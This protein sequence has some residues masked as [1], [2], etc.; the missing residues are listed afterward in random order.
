MSEDYCYDREPGTCPALGEAQAELDAL[1]QTM[2][3][4][5]DLAADAAKQ[6]E[7]LARAF[8]TLTARARSVP[9]ADLHREAA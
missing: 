3:V 1:R 9:E 6:A 4:L 8:R 7:S 2:K 5:G